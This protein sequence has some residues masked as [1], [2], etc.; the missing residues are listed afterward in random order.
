MLTETWLTSD[1][2]GS[3]LIPS[4]YHTFRNDRISRGGGALIAVHS[5]FKCEQIHIPQIV[6]NVSIVLVKIHCGNK[7][8]DLVCPYI[9][10]QPTQ[11]PT[12]CYL[13]L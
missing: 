2:S 10:Q 12:N 6:E 11:I 5:K 3:E 8:L 9:P 13:T 7:S 4:D 1:I